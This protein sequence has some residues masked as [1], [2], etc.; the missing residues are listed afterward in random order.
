MD[1]KITLT[2]SSYLNLNPVVV[3][4]NNSSYVIKFAEKFDAV[5]IKTKGLF[6]VKSTLDIGY[7]LKHEKKIKDDVT[8]IVMER[9]CLFQNT[10]LLDLASLIGAIINANSSGYT[11][12]GDFCDST[13]IPFQSYAPYV[14]AGNSKLVFVSNT[15][16]TV[17]YGSYID[18]II[19]WYVKISNFIHSGISNI[20][21]EEQVVDIT[22]SFSNIEMMLFC[23]RKNVEMDIVKCFNN[24]NTNK[25]FKRVILHDDL[26]DMYNNVSRI[27]H[28]KHRNVY[29]MTN[30]HVIGKQN[31]LTLYFSKHISDEISIEFI[32]VYK[33]GCFKI[34]FIIHQPITLARIVETVNE[35][36]KDNLDELFG[37]LLINDCSTT[38]DTKPMT[39]GDYSPKISRI[40]S[41]Y[42]ISDSKISDIKKLDRLMGFKGI[43]SRFSSNTSISINAFNFY[44][45]NTLFNFNEE[46]ENKGIISENVVKV[47]MLPEIKFA[48]SGDSITIDCTR[49]TSLSEIVFELCFVLPLLKFKNIDKIVENSD[50]VE[51]ILSRLRNIPVKQNLKKLSAMDPELFAP[52]TVGKNA[53][54][55]SAL[56]QIREQR[57]SLITETEYGII[58][59]EHP[60]STFNIENQ[61]NPRQRLYMVCP[62]EKYSF[63]NYHHFNN[64]KC[65]VRCTSKL[66]N[67]GQYSQ[68]A[69]DLNSH[70]MSSLKLVYQ[71]QAIVRYNENLPITRKCY[72]PKEL[73]NAFPDY[74]CVRSELYV[75]GNESIT[76]YMKRVLNAI[77]LIIRRNTVDETYEILTEYDPVHATKYVLVIEP[78]S[79]PE[80]KY[81]VINYTD[82]SLLCVDEHK[83][84]REF[85]R[86][87]YKINKTF[88]EI[89]MIVNR[90]VAKETDLK[91][92]T[93]SLYH[94]FSRIAK[95]GIKL[96]LAEGVVVGVCKKE[97]STDYFYSTPKIIWPYND[98]NSYKAETVYKNIESKIIKLPSFEQL[99]DSMSDSDQ[100]CVNVDGSVGGVFIS[101]KG[102]K[103][104]TCCEPSELPSNYTKEPVMYDCKHYLFI[105]LASGNKF[106]EHRLRNLLN[107]DM[108]YEMIT[109]MYLKKYI[110][111]Y[112]D[113]SSRKDNQEKFMTMIS[114][115]GGFG[116]DHIGYST[117][118]LISLYST[119]LNKDRYTQYLQKNPILYNELDVNDRLYKNMITELKLPHL[120]NEVITHKSFI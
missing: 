100:V 22:H 19:E 114:E 74:I 119:T 104:L 82:Y 18:Q 94:Y 27:Q 103:I 13:K 50:P 43:E 39:A 28:V 69:S 116:E 2:Q 59:K 45:R 34:S 58:H 73:Q 78:E 89:I 101:F 14:C 25:L 115:I 54:A 56:C 97:G 3:K 31:I 90:Y 20:K 53:R 8:S 38:C 88:E 113:Y 106:T 52:R 111:I 23:D 10:T 24:Q 80:L 48:L 44:N 84:L 30:K 72:L 93:M 63:A 47:Q 107:I 91:L 83:S 32:D 17:D 26:L 105:L 108:R 77:P 109:N 79:K 67:P 120:P 1:E 87:L 118:N 42:V 81:L 75:K 76:S 9:L 55:Y 40:V 57:P 36:F 4:Y 85:F 96:V 6:E 95:D 21:P 61:T 15:I 112:P 33:N 51:N 99:R 62:H 7:W 65:V 117:A 68:C 86:S 37:N 46:Y 11:L 35:Y 110:K 49:F 16:Y 64:Q 41:D 60:E 98:V 71:S 29:H 92:E 5:E 12:G 66:S 102:S 70:Y